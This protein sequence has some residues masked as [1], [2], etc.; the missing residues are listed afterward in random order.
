MLL[1]SLASHF[2]IFAKSKGVRDPEGRLFVGNI[3]PK[4]SFS[5]SVYQSADTEKGGRVCRDGNA[6][7]MSDIGPVEQVSY[8]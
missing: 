2:S 4:F 1:I 7:S 8:L 6:M 3:F 5:G